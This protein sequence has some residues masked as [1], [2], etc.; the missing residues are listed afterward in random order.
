[1][2][3]RFWQ[4]FAVAVLVFLASALAILAS[5][6]YGRPILAWIGGAGMIV[7]AVLYLAAA[8]LPNRRVDWDRIRSEQRLWESGPLGRTWL[9]M[10]KR[11]SRLWKL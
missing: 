7:S 6:E 9:R 4:L 3:N 1:V 5:L 11:L 10:R 2:D 8:F